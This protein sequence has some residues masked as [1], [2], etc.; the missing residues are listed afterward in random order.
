VKIVTCGLTNLKPRY[1]SNSHVCF[2]DSDKRASIDRK[3]MRLSDPPEAEKIISG[4]PSVLRHVDPD[5][6]GSDSDHGDFEKFI[7][8]FEAENR[9]QT[10]IRK[11]GRQSAAV[12][13]TSRQHASESVAVASTSRQAVA[14][15]S[16]Q[17]VASSSSQPVA[18]TSR[19]AVP[20]INRS[21]LPEDGNVLKPNAEDGRQRNTAPIEVCFEW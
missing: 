7:S 17:A 18:S 2:A 1:L 4:S 3:V 8:G 9:D 10:V 11:H 5:E 16:R 6:V 20:S 13:S 15:T 19:Q 12:A 14:S 21:V